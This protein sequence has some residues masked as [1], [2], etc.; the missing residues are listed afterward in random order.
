MVERATLGEQFDRDRAARCQTR[1]PIADISSASQRIA[2]VGELAVVAARILRSSKLTGAHVATRSSTKPATLKPASI[3]RIT[4]ARG[5][6]ARVGKLHYGARRRSSCSS[7][8]QLIEPSVRACGQS[9]SRRACLSLSR[10]TAVAERF[11]NGVGRVLRAEDLT[12]LRDEPEIEVDGRTLDHTKSIRISNACTY[13]YS[14]T[15]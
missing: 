14:D 1:G 15:A 6:S 10:R 12:R 5:P 11:M 3:R 9:A 7:R 8:S 13:A 2:N 4:V